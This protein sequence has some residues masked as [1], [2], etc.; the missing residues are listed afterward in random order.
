MTASPAETTAPPAA[1]IAVA[2][3]PAGALR[4]TPLE[5][6]QGMLISSAQAA[7]GL[8]LLRT[9]GLVTGGMAGL[10]M[11]LAYGTGWAFP[12]VFF[13]INLPFYAFAWWKRGP[14]FAVKSFVSV[15]FVAALTAWLPAVLHIE[16]LHPAAAAI[17]FGVVSGVGLLGLFR[18]GSSLG[19]ISIVAVILQD[20]A[21]V[22]AGWFQM[23]F[24]ALIFLAALAV[25]PFDRWLWSVVGGVVLNFVIAMNHRREWYIAG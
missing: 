13:L 7:L 24:D 22:R 20:V 10:A 3:P 2:P 16:Y 9:A 23:G 17:L 5:D 1:E 6:A 18:H 19:G 15:T 14:A 8:D 4:Y 21:G 12:A 25:L 11:L